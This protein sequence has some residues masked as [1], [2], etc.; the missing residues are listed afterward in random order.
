MAIEN[1]VALAQGPLAMVGL[2]T[3]YVV[4]VST[5]LLLVMHKVM[6]S[7]QVDKSL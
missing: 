4:V 6:H 7:I 3:I 5:H 1:L 2:Y